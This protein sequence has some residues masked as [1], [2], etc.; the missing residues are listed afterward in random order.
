V[1]PEERIVTDVQM[2]LARME[3]QLAN[4][5]TEAKRTNGR[6]S[7]LEEDAE[8]QV[9]FRTQVLTVAAVAVGCGTLLTVIVKA[10]EM[11]Q[12]MARGMAK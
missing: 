9:Q 11:V 7:S 10:L 2:A 6:V 1:T 4:I 3:A 5:L 12:M 8:K